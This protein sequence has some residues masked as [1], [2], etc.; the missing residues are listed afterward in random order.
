MAKRPL[1]ANQCP[2]CFGPLTA[3]DPVEWACETCQVTYEPCGN[4]LILRHV[5]LV[6]ADDG[7]TTSDDLVAH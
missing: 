4:F 7:T 6:G 3:I 2:F 5:S 1:F